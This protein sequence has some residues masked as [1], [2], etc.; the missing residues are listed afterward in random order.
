[1]YNLFMKIV[2]YNINGVRAS[3]KLGLIDWI[4]EYNADIYCFQ[5]VRAS[6]DV[7]KELMFKENQQLDL[8][9]MEISNNKLKDYYPI[10]NCGKVAGYAGTMILSKIKPD[11]VFYDMGEFWQDNEGRTTTIII[12]S[13]AI[14]NSYIP[15]GNSRLEFKMQFLDALNNYIAYLCKNYSVICVGDFNVAHNEIDLTNPK[16]CKNKSVFLPIERE[17]FSSLL[18]VG[19]VDSFRFKNPTEVK[20]S[21]RSYRSRYDDSYNSWKYRIDYILTSEDLKNKIL[22]SDILDLPYSDHLPCVA[23]IGKE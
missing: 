19:L 4:A 17:A 12:G 10:F 23:E 21:W 2:S 16:E 18:Q 14:V 13:L 9:S 15:N 7:V 3:V 5:E 6:E 22:S 20:Y 8:F 1:M 11:K